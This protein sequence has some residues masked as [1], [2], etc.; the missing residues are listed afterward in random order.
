MAISYAKLWK[1]LIDRGISKTELMQLTGVSSRT[2]AK[3]SKNETVTT[4]T[5]ARICSVLHCDVGQMMEYREETEPATLYG[6]YRETGV[7]MFRGESYQLVTFSAGGRDY[8]VYASQKAATKGSHIHCKPDGSIYW[9]QL[10][11]F[12][13]MSTPTRDN[14]F[15]LKPETEKGRVTIVLIT[16]KP[17]IITGLDE[18]LCVSHR[19]ILKSDEHFYV[20]SEAAFKLFEPA[21]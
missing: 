17:G 2:M 7:T 18:G 8:T 11:P 12:G 9:E 16:G 3:L 6:C 10:Y 4:D 1:L 21:F 5:I 15:F 20:M 13:G 14:R 19:G